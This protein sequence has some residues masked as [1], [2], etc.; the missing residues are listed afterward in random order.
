MSNE[1]SPMHEKMM[2][3]VRGRYDVGL[4]MLVEHGH[5]VPRVHD[6]R[7]LVY[8]ISRYDLSDIP[9]SDTTDFDANYLLSV[10][11]AV[12]PKVAHI[13]R[14]DHL[15]HIS[16]ASDALIVGKARYR[17]IREAH[18]LMSWDPANV[19]VLTAQP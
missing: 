5:L 7:V 2:E 8:N 3:M 17:F 13:K 15:V 16:T 19:P 9:T 14:G 18:V 12:G 10:V 6:D 4:D 11:V 1:K